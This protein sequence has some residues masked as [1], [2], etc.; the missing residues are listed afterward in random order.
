MQEKL[1]KIRNQIKEL[2]RKEAQ[3]MLQLVKEKAKVRDTLKIPGITKTTWKKLEGQ[4]NRSTLY[5][6]VEKLTA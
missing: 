4:V 1:N 2:K 6:R 5:R 3:L